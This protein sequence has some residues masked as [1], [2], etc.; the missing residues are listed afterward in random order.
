MF[1]IIICQSGRFLLI[2]NIFHFYIVCNAWTMSI[3]IKSHRINCRFSPNSM[4]GYVI[5]CNRKV[6]KSIFIDKSI[7]FFRGL[8]CGPAHETVL[9][10]LIRIKRRNNKIF[11]RNF[12]SAFNFYSLY[13]TRRFIRERSRSRI[14]CN[15]I[16]R[17]PG[18][19]N[20]YSLGSRSHVS[21]ARPTGKHIVIICPG[22]VC[23]T[24]I[25]D[26]VSVL[27]I[28][29]VSRSTSK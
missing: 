6:V 7:F 18:C 12:L 16:Y 29:Y 28:L 4:Q 26:N 15:C 25:I 20:C 17:V 11:Y 9:H 27:N 13:N 19:R 24:I 1:K 14:E 23:H 21:I 10:P 22:R 8:I 2:I 3:C 5:R